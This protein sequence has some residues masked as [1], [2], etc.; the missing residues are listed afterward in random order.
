MQR[1]LLVDDEPNVIKSITRV[2]SSE[3]Y[4]VV[5]ANSGRDALDLM[6]T[7]PVDLVLSDERMPNMTGVELLSAVSRIYPDTIRIILTGHANAQLVFQ[8]ISDGAIYKFLTKPWNDEELVS[9]IREAMALK[10]ESAGKPPDI[11]QKT[12][13]ANGGRGGLMSQTKFDEAAATWDD[14]PERRD[15]AA[16]IVAAIKKEV[17]LVYQNK[18]LEIGCGT[19]LL[20]C[21]LADVL[22][23][24]V[25]IDTSQG[26][27]EILQG[28]VAALG[29]NNVQV[30]NFDIAAG[31]MLETSDFD[32]IYSAM[33][34]HH[35]EDTGAFLA[36][37]RNHLRDG[38]TL[39]V[40]DLEK[41]D[42]SFHEDMD[43]VKHK[44]FDLQD[45]AGKAASAGFADVRFVTAY[46]AV[47]KQDDGTSREYPVFL[48]LA[49]AQ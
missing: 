43:G 6:A 19:G 46:Q 31:Q 18:T 7:M 8:A 15:L 29:I 42:G 10:K 38:G 1:I 24:I 40:A 4:E 14:M 35:I 11:N 33:T 32:F 9:V 17:E 41:E 20:T 12:S 44:G 37:C 49:T 39:A 45:L 16:A 3:P 47:K 48:M 26:M 30:K 25:A 21:D 22:R 5:S 2:L 13:P 27:L 34:I 36:A 23:D 28:K